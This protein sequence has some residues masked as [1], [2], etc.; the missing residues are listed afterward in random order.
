[1]L[2][3]KSKRL[4]IVFEEPGEV[5]CRSRY[6]WSSFIT[7]IILDEKYSLLG[8]ESKV[9][10]DGC[11]GKGLCGEFCMENP[12]GY[13][14]SAVGDYCI[15]IGIGLV[16]KE[17]DIYS[18]FDD[19]KIKPIVWDVIVGDS[20]IELFCSQENFNGF[21][22]DLYKNITLDENTLII[23]YKL[24]NRG[25]RDIVTSEY[26][27]NYFCFNNRNINAEYELAIDFNS[28][29]SKPSEL[30]SC[31]N[32]VFSFQDIN[33][34]LFRSDTE[35]CEGEVGSWKLSHKIEGIRVQESLSKPMKKFAVFATLHIL[36]PEMFVDINVG[37]GESFSWQR[38][39]TFDNL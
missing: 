32:G 31:K 18:F 15:K 9:I 17:K 7:D 13:D 10:G 30:F 14:E 23:D 26:I 39:W 28:A 25:E 11:G 2:K 20:N 16:Q 38:N 4:E 19:L 36:C 35:V 12:L 5:Y 22:Y 29:F 33:E 34:T 6:D 21:A 24:V 27:H 3:L 1:M 8:V 37:A